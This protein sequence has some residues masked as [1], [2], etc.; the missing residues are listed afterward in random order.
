MDSLDLK[1]YP[2]LAKLHEL[3]SEEKG[4]KDMKEFLCDVFSEA[5]ETIRQAQRS[6]EAEAFNVLIALHE[7]KE[8]IDELAESGKYPFPKVIDIIL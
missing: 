3:L 1:K 5:V 2:R 4:Y 6:N 8:L 7:Y